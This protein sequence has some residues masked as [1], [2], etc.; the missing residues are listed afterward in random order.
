[1][2]T[3][4]TTQLAQFLN[5]LAEA[6]DRKPLTPKAI[7]IWFETLKEFST[8]RVMGILHGWTKRNT[9]FPAPAEVWK[10]VNEIT[11]DERE[12]QAASERQDARAPVRFQKSEAGKRALAEIKSLMGPKPT[13]RETWHRC[14]SLNAPGSF[15]Y[16]MAVA[17]LAKLNH[18]RA[19]PQDLEEAA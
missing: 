13:P 19:Q 12:K 14:M 5:G 3:Y 18:K 11:I 8:D 2:K 1:M 4:D 7:E 10:V 9:K 17:A 16:E 6:Y 15:E